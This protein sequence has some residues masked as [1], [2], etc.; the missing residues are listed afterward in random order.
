M[1]YVFLGNGGLN[2]WISLLSCWHLSIA[3]LFALISILL[4][5]MGLVYLPLFTIYITIKTNHPCRYICQSH[6]VS[7]DW[8]PRLWYCCCWSSTAP[9]RSWKVDSKRWKSLLRWRSIHHYR[10]FQRCF[11]GRRLEWPK[12][13]MINTQ[14]SEFLSELIPTSWF[15]QGWLSWKVV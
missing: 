1:S 7:R 9:G 10:R 4:P 15:F 3:I 2:N 8:Q 5:S 13:V 11:L 12:R 6:G 14:S